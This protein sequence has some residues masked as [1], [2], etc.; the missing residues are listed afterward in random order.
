[1]QSPLYVLIHL[2]AIEGS[3]PDHAVI[4]MFIPELGIK[5]YRFKSAVDLYLF[6]AQF[7]CPFLGFGHNQR[8]QF[9]SSVLWEHHY[10]A[11]RNGTF[12]AV[13]ETAGRDR[14]PVI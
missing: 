5:I 1:M 7:L 6:I 9:L 3:A 2:H 14:I 4:N 10:A 11:Q 8:A 12:T 13:I